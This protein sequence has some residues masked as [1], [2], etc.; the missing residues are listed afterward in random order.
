M[1]SSTFDWGIAPWNAEIGSPFL[2]AMTVGRA[3]TWFDII[4]AKRH[5][6]WRIGGTGE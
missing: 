6:Y 4:Q 2:K 5:K 1:N 3:V